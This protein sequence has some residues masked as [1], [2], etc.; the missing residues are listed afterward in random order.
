MLVV[1]VN[2]GCV[3]LCACVCVRLMRR[4]RRRRVTDDRGEDDIGGDDYKG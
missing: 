1:C 3:S 4:R 2:C